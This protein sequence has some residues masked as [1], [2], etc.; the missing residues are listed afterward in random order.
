MANSYLVMFVCLSRRLARVERKNCDNTCPAVPDSRRH[1]WRE[2][3]GGKRKNATEAGKRQKSAR[4]PTLSRRNSGEDRDLAPGKRADLLPAWRYDGR[5]PL[6]DGVHRGLLESATDYRELI[7]DPSRVSQTAYIGWR[8]LRLFVLLA[9]RD[10]SER[11]SHSCGGHGTNIKRFSPSH[12]NYYNI[13][14]KKPYALLAAD[15]CKHRIFGPPYPAT[16]VRVP[17]SHQGLAPAAIRQLGTLDTC[18]LALAS[19]A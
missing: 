1:W 3:K 5:L 16:Y 14:G 10:S 7:M 4:R 2:V 8:L 12:K 9:E 6:H 11:Y 18:R 19:G 17:D 13:A 15:R